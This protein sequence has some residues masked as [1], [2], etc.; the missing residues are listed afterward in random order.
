MASS[1]PPVPPMPTTPP[2]GPTPTSTRL[3]VPQNP[4]QL[5]QQL[6]SILLMCIV[7]LTLTILSTM[8]YVYRK[9]HS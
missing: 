1:S 9:T 5:E 8:L 4:A 3:P 6:R 7:M 2:S